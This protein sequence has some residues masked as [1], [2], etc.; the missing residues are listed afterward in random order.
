[1]VERIAEVSRKALLHVEPRHQQL[2]LDVYVDMAS[3]ILRDGTGGAE[4]DG[5]GFA[6]LTIKV[7][8]RPNS[9]IEY[10]VTHD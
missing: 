1:M 10:V 2:L 5:A 8:G 9:K 7:R 6:E 3:R 4:Q